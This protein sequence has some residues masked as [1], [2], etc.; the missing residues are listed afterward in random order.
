VSS[1]SGEVAVVGA[2][3]SPRRKAPGVHPFEIHA[4]CVKGALDDAGLTLA[5]VDG[6]CAAAGDAGEG[7][8]YSDLFD[9]A[10]YLGIH[11]RWFDST[12]TGGAS[13]ITHAGHAVS[14]IATGRADVVVVSYAACP[15]SWPIAPLFWDGLT[16][17][18]AAGQ[19][20]IPYG[21][22][23]IGSYA[24]VAQRH[25]HEY[26]TTSEQL[27]HVSVT[28]RANAALNPDARFRDP[29]TVSDVLESP[30]IA[31]PLHK[32]DCCPLTEG[33]GAV[34]L[35]SRER[36]AATR[37]PPVWILGFGDELSGLSL[38]RIPELLTTPTAPAAERA[39]AMAGV[40][41]S[42]ID[43]AQVYDGYTIMVVMALED[44][45]FC[46]KGD[47]GPYAASGAIAPDGALPINTDGGGLSSN[48]PGKR[49]I[50]N[51]IE[52]VRQ[53]RG[54]GPGAQVPDAKTALVHGF[55]GF[56]STS[57]VMIL[58]AD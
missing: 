13:P 40:S 28:C 54:E 23:L 33:G 12:E 18:A 58:G 41:P 57:A 21:L 52:G 49:G 16:F 20:E 25:M 6:F 42:D 26:G 47:G 27:A 15:K 1:L 5:D 14:A 37:R 38:T 29:I 2:Y 48:Q 19:F 51:L 34:V 32:F 11:P 8:G 36:A 55:G 9:V 17:P 22:T 44:L 10:D 43:C 3:E 35:T 31:S 53:I 46:A 45:G 39:Y 7:G 50:F 24:M 56:F 30:M 4:E